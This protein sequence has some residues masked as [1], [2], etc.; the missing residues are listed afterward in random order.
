MLVLSRRTQE[1]VI[2]GAPDHSHRLLKV[3]V[4]DIRGTQVK[5]GFDVDSDI[6]VHRLEVWERMNGD[7]NGNGNGNGNGHA[8]RL[9]ED[10][11]ELVL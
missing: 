5:L 1:S 7:G 8:G 2:V 6:P 11:D 3:T 4:L 10:H 9:T